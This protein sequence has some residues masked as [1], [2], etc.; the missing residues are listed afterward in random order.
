MTTTARLIID[1]LGGYR[2]V[3]ANLGVEP[4]RVH[5]WTR[6]GVPA[7]Y[8]HELVIMGGAAQPAVAVTIPELQEAWA[9]GADARKAAQS[10]P[11]ALCGAA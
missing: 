6:R 10:A 7:R 5:N 3:A 9:N 1:R 4:M 11:R 2:V 8:W